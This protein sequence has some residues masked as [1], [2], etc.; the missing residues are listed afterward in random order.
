MISN[1]A[2][3]NAEEEEEEEEEAHTRAV[4]RRSCGTMPIIL[5][6]IMQIGT[7]QFTCCC[8]RVLES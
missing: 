4:A 3:Y 5:D 1:T 8:C 2:I 6:R 7:F